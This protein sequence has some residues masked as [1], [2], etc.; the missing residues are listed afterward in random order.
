MVAEIKQYLKRLYVKREM[1]ETGDR[2]VVAVG[3]V[4][5]A[6]ARRSPRALRHRGR[7]RRERGR[8]GGGARGDRRRR[9]ERPWSRRATT[10]RPLRQERRGDWK[11]SH[12]SEAR[13]P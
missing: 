3:L 5:E 2:P 9:A 12:S 11:T 4:I 7:E 6:L 8:K 10:H 13:R 1:G